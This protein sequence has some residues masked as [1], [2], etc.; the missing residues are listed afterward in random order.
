LSIVIAFV[1]APP[2]SKLDRKN[3]PG[4]KPESPVLDSVPASKVGAI[5]LSDASS[6]ISQHSEKKKVETVKNE[7]VPSESISEQKH[8]P[9]VKVV[10]TLLSHVMPSN[11]CAKKERHKLM[12]CLACASF[13]AFLSRR[14]TKG[15][16]CQRSANKSR[17][18]NNFS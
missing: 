10:V 4:S 1:G 7:H 3:K 5:Y 2:P 12:S 9:V 11:L 13:A 18:E 15:S 14:P 8:D 16:C 6:P 17:G